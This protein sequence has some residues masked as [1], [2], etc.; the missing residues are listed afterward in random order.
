MAYLDLAE[1][2]QLVE[3]SWLLSATRFAP[4]SF[5]EEDHCEALRTTPHDLPNQPNLLADLVRD[6]VEKTTGSRPDGPVR[7]LT[8]LRHWGLY[9]SPLNLFFCFSS[10]GEQLEAIVAEVSNTPWNER[11]FYVLSTANRANVSGELS[12]PRYLRYEHLKDFHVSPFRKLGETYRWRL[13]LPSE[14]LPV[15]IQS[16]EEGTTTFAA[17]MT[18]RRRRW[19]EWQLAAALARRPAN[20]LNILAAIHWQALR[21]WLKRCPYIPHPHVLAAATAPTVPGVIARDSV[22][23]DSAA[24]DS[25]PG[26]ALRGDSCI[27]GLGNSK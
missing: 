27:S 20:T 19:S 21:L 9:F 3:R 15:G 6:F 11:R 25:D 14:R 10:T 17:S 2:P 16:V 12:G 13:N 22:A 24:I 8:Q 5:R 26:T 18:L 23:K 7:V 1:V 4:A